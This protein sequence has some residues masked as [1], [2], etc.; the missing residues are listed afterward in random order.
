MDYLQLLRENDDPTQWEYPRDFDYHLATTEFAKFADELS[1]AQGVALKTETGVIIQDNSFHSQICIP[2]PGDRSAVNRFS[3][4][5]KMVTVSEDES[6]PKEMLSTM[7][8]LFSRHGY[9]YVPASILD[10]P[11]TGR[12]PGVTGIRTWWIRYFDWV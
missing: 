9:V 12:N 5:G 11:Y 6:V 10:Q 2:L 7:K 4:F 3:N 8:E 1:M